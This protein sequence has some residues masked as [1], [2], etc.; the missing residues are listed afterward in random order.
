MKDNKKVKEYLEAKKNC[1]SAR[2]AT[3]ESNINKEK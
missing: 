3:E 2:K 1:F